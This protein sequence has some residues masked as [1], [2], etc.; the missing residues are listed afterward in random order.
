MKKRQTMFYVLLP[1]VITIS[2]Y[3]VFYSRIGCKPSEAGFWLIIAM[4]MS[5]GAALTRFILW[6]KLKK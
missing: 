5:I 2:L 6:S 4:G 1:V 3:M